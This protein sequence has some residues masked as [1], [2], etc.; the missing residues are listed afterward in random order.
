MAKFRCNLSGNIFEFNNE[1]D[2]LDMQKHPQ[3]T[4]IPDALQTKVKKTTK[5]KV[6][7][8]EDK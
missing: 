2:I 3:Y 6:T 7:K 1:Y 5:E 8:K 4:E